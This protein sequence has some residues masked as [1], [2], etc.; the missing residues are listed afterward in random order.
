MSRA[1]FNIRFDQL[2]RVPGF[3]IH[4]EM[5]LLVSELGMTPAEVIDPVRRRSARL[6][7]IAD[8]VE[9]SNEAEEVSFILTLCLRIQNTSFEGPEFA[10]LCTT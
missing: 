2:R 9:Q 5:A 3:S 6:L 1:F 10:L 7:R 4:D 8:S